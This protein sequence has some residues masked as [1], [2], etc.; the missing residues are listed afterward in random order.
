MAGIGF[1][2]KKL[3]YKRGIGATLKAYFYSTFVSIGPVI[4]SVLAITFLQYILRIL[5]VD[6]TEMELLQATI[7]YSFMFAVITSS[8]FCM[9]IS[10]YLSDVLFSEKKEDILPALI[11]S[12]TLALMIC[13]AFGIIF[14][15][16][17]PLPTD[18]KV[19]S[20]LLYIGIV[21]EMLL[22]VFVSA[23]NDYKEVSLAFVVGFLVAILVGYVVN[24][25][26]ILEITN[27]VILSFDICI[28]IVSVMLVRSINKFFN[29]KSK[30]HLS[31]F[32]AF[33]K[34]FP[35]WIINTFYTSGLY[36]HFFA[37]WF[38]AEIAQ[39]VRG[40]YLYAPHYDIPASFAFLTIMPTLVLFVVKLETGFYLKYRS[41]FHMI[42]NGA[43]YEDIKV[44]K[45]E[46]RK[47]L[48][49]EIIYIMEI[50]LF[51]SILAMVLGLK[52]LPYLGFTASM[53]DMYS[54]LITGYYCA[55]ITFVIMTILL[56]FNDVKSAIIISA[57][58][59]LFGFVFSYVSI[60]FGEAYYGVGFFV[61]SLLALVIALIRLKVYM[62]NIEFHVFCK[63]VSW[64]NKDKSKFDKWID[65][66]NRLG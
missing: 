30:T 49:K 45:I 36:T 47:V 34:I 58:L 46:M 44:A 42:N 23:I 4:V 55:V 11:T 41:Y 31:F 10:R 27:T 20:Y 53:I 1:Q 22:A 18:Y 65:K 12:I 40:T 64:V 54:I 66:L 50:Q 60:Q 29:K 56:Y 17:S 43:C 33:H 52:F 13:G 8:G 26:E 7:M 9:Y 61:G 59:T 37:Y 63:S 57:S 6:R 25:F 28:F 38:F 16:R 21:V 35:L 62:V 14:Y 39:T 32:K 5:E 48:N 24:E 3:F 19:L 2:L 15:L 51:F